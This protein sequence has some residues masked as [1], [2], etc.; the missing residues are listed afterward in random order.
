MTIFK[1]S[2]YKFNVFGI[3]ADTSEGLPPHAIHFR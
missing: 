1:K 2:V 3:T